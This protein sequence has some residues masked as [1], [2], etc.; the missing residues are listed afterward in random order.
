[1]SNRL[2]TILTLALLAASVAAPDLRAFAEPSNAAIRSKQAEAAAVQT[3]LDQ[4]AVEL[5]E[6]IEEYNAVRE[7]RERTLSEI[8]RTRVELEEAERDLNEANAVLSK[9]AAGIYRDGPV[10]AIAIL[11]GTSSFPDFLNRMD[12]LLR[13]SQRD[14]RTVLAVKEAKAR[15]EAT[16]RALET[17][18]AEEAALLQRERAEA[19]RIEAGIAAQSAYL[20]ELNREVK[21]L[22]EKERQRQR[23]LAEERARRA[24]EAVRRSGLTFDPGS[25]TSGRPEV[26]TAALRFLGVPYV[27]GGTSPSGF[28]CSGLTYYC[29]RE[30]GVSIPRTS[31]TQFRSGQH[32][33][34]NRRDLL[35]AGDLVFFGRDGNPERVH[36]VG[37]YVKDDLFIHAPATGDV[38]KVDSL[39]DRIAA[40]G[41]YVGA[42]RF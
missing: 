15:V 23:A 22:I 29:Y 13:I 36:H 4:M 16:E 2:R 31:R 18:A 30:I 40:K 9:R 5:E 3:R 12:L 25:L 32:I 37:I 10:D 42:S 14:A 38:V 34:P 6:Q 11:L 21:A 41:D 19:A 17:R 26:V 28:D 33:P 35:V 1:M 39:A 8:R 24:A 27:W 20:E 7:E